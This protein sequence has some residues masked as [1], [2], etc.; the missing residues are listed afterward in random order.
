MFASKPG[1]KGAVMFFKRRWDDV[2]R[3]SGYPVP[4]HDMDDEVFRNRPVAD[5]QR[6]DP[7]PERVSAEKVPVPAPNP[8]PRYTGP[9]RRVPRVPV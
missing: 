5:I 3:T 2:F 4:S 8:P 1:R 7:V 6:D 9:E